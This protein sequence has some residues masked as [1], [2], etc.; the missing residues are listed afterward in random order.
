MPRAATIQSTERGHAKRDN[1]AVLNSARE[2][3]MSKALRQAIKVPIIENPVAFLECNAGRIAL[4]NCMNPR[5]DWF[6]R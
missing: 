2:Q 5:R 6:I 4:C 1:V 3:I